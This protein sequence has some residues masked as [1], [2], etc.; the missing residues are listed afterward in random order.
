MRNIDTARHFNLLL[1]QDFPVI[2]TVLG[3]GKSV[4][5]TVYRPPGRVVLLDRTAK[6]SKKSTSRAKN[7]ERK[8]TYLYLFST[9]S[10]FFPYI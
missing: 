9:F 3:H 5:I 6:F 2:V 10:L 4:T 7:Y 1:V 8:D